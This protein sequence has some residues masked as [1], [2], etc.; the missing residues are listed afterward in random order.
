[1]KQKNQLWIIGILLVIITITSLVIIS[2]AYKKFVFIPGYSTPE[3][4]LSTFLNAVKKGDKTTASKC[5]NLN[6]S[7]KILL[8]MFMK[9]RSQL[10]DFSIAEKTQYIKI[11]WDIKLKSNP[12]D[13]KIANLE[14]ILVY[15]RNKQNEKRFRF[16]KYAD[17]KKEKIFVFR[18]FLFKKNIEKWKIEKFLS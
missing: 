9:D 18:R 1:M 12:E 10:V 6:D 5:I 14:A 4:T 3:Q 13:A 8:V 16:Y 2:G 15:K 7:N 11:E 17:F